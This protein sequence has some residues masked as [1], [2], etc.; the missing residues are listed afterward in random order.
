MIFS[1]ARSAT[2][3][4]PQTPTE[5]K[6]RRGGRG[7]LLLT[8]WHPLTRR[9]CHGWAL[10]LG[11]LRRRCPRRRTLAPALLRGLAGFLR[12]GGRLLHRHLGRGAPAPLRR[13]NLA[14]HLGRAPA[15]PG[16]SSRQRHDAKHGGE[17]RS[18]SSHDAG[19]AVGAKHG[20]AGGGSEDPGNRKEGMRNSEERALLAE[21][22]GNR[23]VTIALAKGA[24]WEPT[25]C[26][27]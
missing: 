5:R 9:P 24:N 23:G 17:A 26:V 25:S 27:S 2:H 22:S 12:G 3:R 15:V 10:A 4:T 13:R 18:A 16:D 19:D 11:L 20:H 21:R 6:E 1:E 8:R 14:P 7:A